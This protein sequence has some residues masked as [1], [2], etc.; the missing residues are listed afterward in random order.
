MEL[1]HS[2]NEIDNNNINSAV[3][4]NSANSHTDDG[5]A[6]I[7]TVDAVNS[8]L[9]EKHLLAVQHSLKEEI[10]EEKRRITQLL[11]R[12]RDIHRQMP[13]DALE[14]LNALRQLKPAMEMNGVRILAESCV[15]EVRRSVRFLVIL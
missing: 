10:A 13:P 14:R 7:N 3:N 4:N 11:S 2:S 5:G 6:K 1:P 12:L 15:D 8:A 9:L